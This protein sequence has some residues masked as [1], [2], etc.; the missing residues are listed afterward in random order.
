MTLGTDISAHNGLYNFDKAKAN[1]VEFVIL[2]AS[3]RDFADPLFVRNM[4]RGK[5][6]GIQLGAYHFL[7]YTQA[8]Y[9]V[10]QEAEFG[11]AQARKFLEIV[12]PYILDGT[13]KISLIKPANSVK[14][15]AS[16]WLDIEKAYDWEALTSPVQT[17]VWKIAEAFRLKVLETVRQYKP[18]MNCGQYSSQYLLQ[19][20]A[21]PFIIPPWLAWYTEIYNPSYS[22]KKP[23]GTYY[24]AT[25]KWKGAWLI[26]QYSST[27]D[28]VF[29]GNAAGNQYIDLNKL[30][31][32]YSLIGSPIPEPAPTPINQRLVDIKSVQ[33]ASLNM[34][35]GAG[36][37]Y[38]IIK[39][40]AK[41]TVVECLEYKDVTGNLW[42]RVGQGQWCCVK[43]GTVTYLS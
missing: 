30:N 24:Y 5:N 20:P 25:G 17:R 35:S 39:P 27:G 42:A 11:K 7:D 23:D 26:H 8:H 40:L 14:V 32:E 3:Q 19:D 15:D 9:A 28:G 41:G 38:P 36:V 2:K 6:K 37:N 4:E 31:P 21:N 22:Y 16:L 10:G 33:V 12:L 29:Y 13:L 34:R 18:D 1:D 43:G